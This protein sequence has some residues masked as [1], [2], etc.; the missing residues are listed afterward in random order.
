MNMS[1]KRDRCSLSKFF[2]VR[3]L[4]H[5]FALLFTA[6]NYAWTFTHKSQLIQSFSSITHWLLP[7]LL[8]LTELSRR[9]LN[10]ARFPPFFLSAS[11]LGSPVNA[12]P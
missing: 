7:S 11:F 6:Q 3:S 4:S 10:Y 12:V 1:S 2:L 8:F 9:S 5:V